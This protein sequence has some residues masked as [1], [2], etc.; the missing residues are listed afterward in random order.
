MKISFLNYEMAVRQ[1]AHCRIL[2][3]IVQR[4]IIAEDHSSPPPVTI[5]F[6]KPAEQLSMGI[7]H[8]LVLPE[9]SS[10]AGTV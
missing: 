6:E 1:R 8:S 9:P 4:T 3:N 2:F 5:I 7:L 10:L